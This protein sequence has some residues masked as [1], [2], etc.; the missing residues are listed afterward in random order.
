MLSASVSCEASASS[1]LFMMSSPPDGK[2]PPRNAICSA[3]VF[4]SATKP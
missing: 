3:I 4:G 2:T 1:W